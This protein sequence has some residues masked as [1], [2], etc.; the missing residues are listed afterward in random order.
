M[1]EVHP[2]FFIL[3]EKKH[4]AF[5]QVADTVSTTILISAQLKNQVFPVLRLC[6]WFHRSRSFEG[7]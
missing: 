2:F 3:S 5:G 7:S 1:L 6:D 4:L